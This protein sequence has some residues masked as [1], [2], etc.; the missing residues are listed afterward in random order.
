MRAGFRVLYKGEIALRGAG[1]AAFRQVRAVRKKQ[2]RPATKG[3]QIALRGK[4][5]VDYL[6][7]QG[8]YDSVNQTMRA[9]QDEIGWSAQRPL[10][11]DSGEISLS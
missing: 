7:Q 1:A 9:A 8:V 6:K 10:L 3:A 5:A 4:Q 11:G 2:A